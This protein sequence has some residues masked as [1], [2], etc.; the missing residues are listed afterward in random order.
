MLDIR[1]ACFKNLVFQN[2]SKS[3]KKVTL[4]TWF[5]SENE[6]FNMEFTWNNILV[7]EKFFTFFFYKCAYTKT[8]TIHR[9]STL[10]FMAIHVYATQPHATFIYIYVLMLLEYLSHAATSHHSLELIWNSTFFVTV[11]LCVVTRRSTTGGHKYFRGGCSLH[12]H[13][14]SNPSQNMCSLWCPKKR[15]S[16]TDSMGGNKG[17]QLQKR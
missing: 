10:K 3:L 16:I 11:V 14:T 2:M 4:E 6:S 12:L 15:G 17:G 7:K 13:D 8:S 5:H 9:K 1:R